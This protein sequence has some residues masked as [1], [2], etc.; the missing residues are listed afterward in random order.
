M[1]DDPDIT[2]LRSLDYFKR[3]FYKHLVPNGT[4]TLTRYPRLP[5]F[6]FKVTRTGSPRSLVGTYSSCGR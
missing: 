2:L 1:L 3:R 6:F 5:Y 4:K